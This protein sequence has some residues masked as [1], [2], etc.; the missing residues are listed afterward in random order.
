MLCFMA[1]SMETAEA[2]ISFDDDVDDGTPAAPIDGLLSLGLA[3][4]AYYGIRK[5]VKKGQ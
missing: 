1:L 3:A 5:I 4:G 2:H